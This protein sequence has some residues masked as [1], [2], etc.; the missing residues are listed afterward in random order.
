M[1]KRISRVPI[2][3]E[4]EA[5]AKLYLCLSKFFKVLANPTRL[6]LLEL[7]SEKKESYTKQNSS[8]K[9]EK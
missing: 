9:G 2:T 7:L 1:G 4:I 8:L 5:K 6:Q 3:P